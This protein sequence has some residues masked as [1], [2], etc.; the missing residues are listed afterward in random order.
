MFMRITI[1]A[2]AVLA[3]AVMSFA[4]SEV[5]HAQLTDSLGTQVDLAP[6]DSST[7]MAELEEGALVHWDAPSLTPYAVY[8]NGRLAQILWYCGTGPESTGPGSMGKLIYRNW[9]GGA[10]DISVYPISIWRGTIGDWLIANSQVIQFEFP[11]PPRTEPGYSSSATG[12]SA[13]MSQRSRR[14]VDPD[15]PPAVSPPGKL[16]AP[17]GIE[18][19]QT[20]FRVEW[21]AASDTGSSSVIR[22]KLQY[23][24]S[25]DT[26]FKDVS[27][28]PSGTT[29]GYNILDRRG[30]SI[31]PGASYDVRVRACNSDGC[32]PWSDT[33]TVTT[34]SPPPPPRKAE[35]TPPPAPQAS[36]PP[37]RLRFSP[38]SVRSASGSVRPASGSVRPASGSVR[39]AS[40]SVRPASGS[41]RSASG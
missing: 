20:S 6:G 7:K 37:A 23:K 22:Y 31:N 8:K 10:G 9:K 15:P 35:S 1:A 32:G 34:Q 41:V 25:S 30:Q 14:S 12:A 24:P 33:M 18:V 21:D 11:N 17:R 4:S 29:R 36:S 27:P 40:G 38:T 2:L 39:P 13:V 5:S 19:R 26:T 16:S 3:V 28:F